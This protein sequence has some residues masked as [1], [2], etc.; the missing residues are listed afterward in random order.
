MIDFETKVFTRV[1]DKVASLCAEGY[2][3]SKPLPV[4]P[5]LP[6]CVLYEMDNSTVRS[7]QSS[8]PVENF[9]MITYQLEVFAGTKKTAKKILNAADGEMISMNFNRM[10]GQY[11]PTLDNP[12]VV[13]YVARY[14]AIVDQEGNLYR[15]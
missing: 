13:R 7:R 5:K 2:C 4:K 12:Q 8:T 11:L 15:T 9:A 10:S 1:Y 6:A 3:L 14:E